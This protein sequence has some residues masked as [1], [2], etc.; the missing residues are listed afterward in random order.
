MHDFWKEIWKIREQ[1]WTQIVK[2]ALHVNV[3]VLCFCSTV[4]GML[5]LKFGTVIVDLKNV[6]YVFD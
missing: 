6:W 3:T 1:M 2:L 5:K 4:L